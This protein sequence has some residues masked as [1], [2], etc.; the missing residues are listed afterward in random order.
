[1]DISVDYHLKLGLK[2]IERGVDMLWLADDVGGEHALLVSPS[3]F[4]EMIKPKI[5]DTR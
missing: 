3:T 1:M 2:L 4:R 5:G